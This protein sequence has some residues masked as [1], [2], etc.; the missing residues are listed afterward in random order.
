MLIN[1]KTLPEDVAKIVEGKLNYKEI[2]DY[3]FITD[4]LKD[5]KMKNF[6]KYSLFINIG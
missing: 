4:S 5:G 6:E 2:L 1:P 3:N